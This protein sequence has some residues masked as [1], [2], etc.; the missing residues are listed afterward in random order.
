VLAGCGATD[1]QQVQAKVEQFFHA[2]VGRQYRTLCEQVLA[3]ALTARFA[4]QGLR[5]EQAM[6][7]SLANVHNPV[8]SIGRVT[9][10]GNTAEVVT[11][12]GA[13]GQRGAFET[14]ELVKTANGWRIAS[15]AAPRLTRHP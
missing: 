4:S 14:I 1:R 7:I 5:C 13:S 6:Q 9:V 15:L 11:L 8:L 2:I 3:P 12:T 10:T